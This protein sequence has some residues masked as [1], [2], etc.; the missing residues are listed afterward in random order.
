MSATLAEPLARELNTREM[1]QRVNDLRSI[2]NIT[3][4]FYLVREW[5]LVALVIGLT[6][7]FYEYRECWDLSWAWNVPVTLV[8]VILIGAGQH[9][10]TNLGH[11]ASHYMLF[12]NRLLNELVSDWLCMFPML[13]CTH[14]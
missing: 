9:R 7:L 1:H 10:L 8:A 12:R 3:N 2:D 11:E 6:I 5:L 14:H 4:W 13:S